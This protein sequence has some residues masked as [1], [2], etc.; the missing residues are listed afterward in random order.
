MIIFHKTN[1]RI[2]KVLTFLPPQTFAWP[3]LDGLEALFS[4]EVQGTP[5]VKDY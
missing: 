5:V 2:F 4:Y 1:V 3:I